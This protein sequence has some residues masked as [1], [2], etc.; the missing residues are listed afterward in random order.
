[1]VASVY[2]LNSLYLLALNLKKLIFDFSDGVHISGYILYSD[3]EKCV[4]ETT[5]HKMGL[6]CR[7]SA[8]IM[9]KSSFSFSK[10][11]DSLNCSNNDINIVYQNIL[12][13]YYGCAI[14]N[15]DTSEV[16]EFETVDLFKERYKCPIWVVYAAIALGLS[17]IV[18]CI[19]CTCCCCCRCC[20]CPCL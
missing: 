11:I 1:M 16:Y 10:S 5:A 2:F 20:C 15:I 3:K 7:V 18:V 6:Q 14:M 8:W 12:A 4:I 19:I 13:C 9:K 17:F